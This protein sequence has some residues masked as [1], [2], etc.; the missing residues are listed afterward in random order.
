ML[1]TTLLMHNLLGGDYKFNIIIRLEK[2]EA[3]K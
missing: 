2:T 3:L 1:T